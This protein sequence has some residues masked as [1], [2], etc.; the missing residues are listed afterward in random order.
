MLQKL[1]RWSKISW[2]WWYWDKGLGIISPLSAS[3]KKNTILR[4]NNWDAS[5]CRTCCLFPCLRRSHCHGHGGN[6][7]A[8]CFIVN[9]IVSWSHSSRV[10]TMLLSCTNFAKTTIILIMMDQNLA[11]VYQSYTGCESLILI[12]WGS[13]NQ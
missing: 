10:W 3:Q 9:R 5:Q 1:P 4:H 6:T 2:R 7:S 11:I 13:F 8:C 12:I